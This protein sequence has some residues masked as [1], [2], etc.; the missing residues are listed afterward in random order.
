MSSVVRLAIP[1]AALIVGSLLA[2]GGSPVNSES[3]IAD[4]LM[5][6]QDAVVGDSA[7]LALATNTPRARATPTSTPMPDPD[8]LRRLQ[9]TAT[10]TPEPEREITRST[11]TSTPER[12][13]I[14]LLPGGLEVERTTPPHTLD[15][16]PGI[17]VMVEPHGWY[18]Q[19]EVTTSDEAYHWLAICFQGQPNTTDPGEFIANVCTTVKYAGVDSQKGHSSTFHADGLHPGTPYI[20]AALAVKSSGDE[21]TWGPFSTLKR[22]LEWRIDEIYVGDDSD[23][24]S[25]GDLHFLFTMKSD[26]ASK[27]DDL[28]L[29]EDGTDSESSVFPDMVI[30][31]EDDDS[32]VLTLSVVGAD[33]DTGCDFIVCTLDSETMFGQCASSS[34]WDRA[35]AWKTVAVWNQNDFDIVSN[36][37]P[38]ED[39]SGFL[40]LKAKGDSLEFTVKS[41]VAVLYGP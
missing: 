18:A 3:S 19:V 8:D 5:D 6:A 28:D 30:R 35:C 1:L 2:A 15:L 27:D 31:I 41:H 40:E 37:G 21:M 32:P 33:D 10:S 20:F 34:E 12:I 38:Y 24:L 7:R 36:I 29:P 26:N 22:N 11:P 16:E 25:G 9:P 4:S 23:D 17:F 14:P 13:Q 39:W